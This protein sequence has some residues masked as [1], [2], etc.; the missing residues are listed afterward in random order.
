[1][2]SYA[3]DTRMQL[4]PMV[5]EQTNRGE[6]ATTSFASAEGQHHLHRHANRRRRRE[7]AIAQMLFLELR[8]R[9]RTS[10]CTLNSRAAR[11]RLDSRFT[12]R[13]SSSGRRAD[14]LHRAGGVDCGGAAGGGHKGKRYFC[15]SHPDPPALDVGARRAATDI[16]LAAGILR[17][18]ERINE[19]LVQH[20]T[21]G[22]NGSGRHRTGLHHVGGP[23]RNTVLSM[24][25]SASAPNR[26]LVRPGESVAGA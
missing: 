11:L 14:D 22:Q 19:I 15:C 7:P 5:V 8:T 21:A 18:R 17:M 2:P 3:A 1:M 25:S 16:D 13:C 23:G 20:G 4:V 26:S 6:R 12:T 10:R 9:T 24:M